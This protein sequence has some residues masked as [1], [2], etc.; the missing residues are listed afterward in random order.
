[1]GL[2]G[3]FVGWY[4]GFDVLLSLYFCAF[5]TIV[6]VW[7]FVCLLTVVWCW[8]LI[9][10]CFVVVGLLCELWCVS[11]GLD[12]VCMVLDIGITFVVLLAV[13]L[14]IWG[15]CYLFVV[16]VVCC[17]FGVCV[18]VVL[19]YCYWMNGLGLGGWI[20]GWCLFWV[21]VVFL[22]LVVIEYLFVVG[23]LVVV[24]FGLGFWIVCFGWVCW[25]VG[26]LIN[27]VLGGLVCLFWVGV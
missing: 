5:I 16:I 17:W 4:C 22:L 3:W 26:W 12:W 6:V 8:G 21:V 13:C 24:C 11:L 25:L 19:G 7:G 15:V 20:G 18:G 23:L 9:E 10:D 14:V 1:M 27:F 2:I